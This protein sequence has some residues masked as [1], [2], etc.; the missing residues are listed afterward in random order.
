MVA[1]HKSS[2]SI[3][4]NQ[5]EELSHEISVRYTDETN[6]VSSAERSILFN[7]VKTVP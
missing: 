3:F 6:I 4:P 1:L 7:F 2:C 5:M